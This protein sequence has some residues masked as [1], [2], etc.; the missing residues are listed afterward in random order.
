MVTLTAW[1]KTG[2]GP[3]D[4]PA[5]RDVLEKGL[6][7]LTNVP[8]DLCQIHNLGAVKVKGTEQQVTSIDYIELAR[9]DERAYYV[10]SG[11]VTMTAGDVAVIPV[12]QDPF[13]TMRAYGNFPSARGHMIR[14]SRQRGYTGR[15]CI[16]DPL[17]TPSFP[18]LRQF[19]TAFDP[20]DDG[21][22]DAGY[23]HVVASTVSLNE[24][25]DSQWN[26]NDLY[27]VDFATGKVTASWL[28]EKSSETEVIVELEIN[29]AD[30]PV[31][32]RTVTSGYGLYLNPPSKVLKALWGIN[33]ASSILG[34]YALP[35]NLFE[36]TK[37][38]PYFISSI[39]MKSKKVEFGSI[40]QTPEQL[41]AGYS[42][43]DADLVKNNANLITFSDRYR[44][45]ILSP[46]SG[47]QQISKGYSTTGTVIC[48]AD[49]RLHG[50][51]YFIMPEAVKEGQT[52]V[53]A[54]NMA[55]LFSRGVP[56]GEW[57]SVPL[58]FSGASGWAS[59]QAAFVLRDDMQ[60]H[61][62]QYKNDYEMYDAP[63]QLLN[64]GVSAITGNINWENADYI[65]SKRATAGRR[66]TPYIDSITP[67][68]EQ[69]GLLSSALGVVGNGLGAL[70]RMAGIS[71]DILAPI[72]SA[73]RNNLVRSQ[74]R[75]RGISQY[76]LNNHYVAPT[77]TGIP[78]TTWQGLIGNGVIIYV[79]YPDPEDVKK[80][81]RMAK[82]F[83]VAEDS[84]PNKIINLAT[85]IS[86]DDPM[87]YVQASLRFI[88]ISPYAPVSAALIA[89]AE[90]ALEIGV[91]FWQVL[92]C[93]YK[94]DS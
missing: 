70:G 26:P 44:I 60:T 40:F 14:S 10:V 35:K 46:V 68:P 93:D 43:P 31:T 7:T 16:I 41:Y 29:E 5:T 47:S 21:G 39:K 92:P 87:T 54:Y 20:E 94:G 83:G 3:V 71:D 89:D 49:P 13:L 25:T 50:K 75:N 74:E 61:L 27:N 88:Q 73:S 23:Y 80:W 78:A 86:K 58:S 4:L 85:P 72:S 66:N 91:R 15:N 76:M 18:P 36:I 84:Y 11:P 65:Q 90:A 38:G 55:Q 45:G 67:I 9:E 8:V 52:A 56:G 42:G 57:E 2:L 1:S 63:G 32:F 12:V 62:S 64:Q 53:L 19:L 81:A 34:S 79:E 24:P 33:G 30:G 37:T 28:P 48:V 69:S 51:P 59:E 6:K 77:T 82:Y 17:M 22:R